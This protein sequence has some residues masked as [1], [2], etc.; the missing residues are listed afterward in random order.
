MS[1]MRKKYYY[2]FVQDGKGWDAQEKKKNAALCEHHH[3]SGSSC[4]SVSHAI[5][6]HE[7]F[8]LQK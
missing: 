6:S 8:D 1:L 7:L 4:V 2:L 3:L 5:R